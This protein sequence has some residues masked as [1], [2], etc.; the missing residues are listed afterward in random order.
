MARKVIAGNL[1]LFTG[2]AS[3]DVCFDDNRNLSV[4]EDVVLSFILHVSAAKP[5]CNFSR[6][7]NLFSNTLNN[8]LHNFIFR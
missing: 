8:Y 6:L 1:A 4:S 7:H 5:R 3:P 2:R